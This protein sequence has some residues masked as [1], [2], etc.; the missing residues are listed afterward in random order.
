MYH[1][2]HDESTCDDVMCLLQMAAVIPVGGPV[3]RIEVTIFKEY[4]I[5]SGV[6]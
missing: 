5:C 4:V 6:I 2:L 3:M 1:Q